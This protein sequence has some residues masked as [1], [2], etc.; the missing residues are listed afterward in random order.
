M[1]ASTEEMLTKHPFGQNAVEEHKKRMFVEVR[2]AF[3]ENRN[4]TSDTK[5]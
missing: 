1:A 2:A 3:C 5:E 4:L